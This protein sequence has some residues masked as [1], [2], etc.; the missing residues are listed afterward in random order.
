MKVASD[1][2]F[3]IGEPADV[4]HA[5]RGEYLS[6]HLL[7]DFRKS[8]LLYHRKRCG[9]IPDEDRP[10]YV[11]GRAVHTLILEGRK[12]FWEEYEVGGPINPKTG[13]P[14]G[15]TTKTFQEWQATHGKPVLTNDQY[16]L[17]AQMAAGVKRSDVGSELLADGVAEGVGRPTACVGRCELG[18]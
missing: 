6:S 7:A 15:A 3:L 8:P 18:H 5:R 9:L 4:Y 10:A 14:F 13:Q 11:I 2:E 1:F 16:N 12:R 17:V